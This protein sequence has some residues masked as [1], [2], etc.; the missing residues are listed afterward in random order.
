[1]WAPDCIFRNGNYYFYFPSTP[2]DS[3]YGKGFTI[4]VAVAHNPE[5]PFIPQDQP[6]KGVHGI[7]PNV[8]IDKDGQAYL[9]W[10]QGNIYAARLKDNMLE[11]ASDPVIL[12]DL[13]VK[14]LK[15][16]PFL[17]ERKGIYYLTY[18]HVRNKTES[19]EYATADNPMGPFTVRGVIMDESTTGCWTNHQSIV[20]YKDQWYL[21]YHHN[22]WSPGFDKARSVRIDSLFFNDDGTIRKVIPTLRGVGLTPAT[23][24]IEP[25]RY[26]RISETGASIA[27]LDT[28]DH[29]RGWKTILAGANAWVQYNSVDFGDRPLQKV[30]LRV[31]SDGAGL[32]EIRTEAPDGPVLAAIPVPAG[33]EGWRIVT[34]PLLR[35]SPAIHHLFIVSKKEQPVEIDWIRFE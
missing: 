6:I 8:F 12:R 14:G 29:F 15:E 16:G 22:D 31:S 5:G 26:S 27:F 19:L 11:L 13:P 30:I 35:F 9:Y 23:E 2:R 34:A 3:S 18:P 1:M 33:V 7:D 10:A 4:G 17:F 21:F 20:Q 25:D 28:L 32:L 24:Y